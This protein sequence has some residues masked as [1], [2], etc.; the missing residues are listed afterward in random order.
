MRR[1]GISGVAQP[2][3]LLRRAL[4]AAAAVAIALAPVH[5]LVRGRG[6]AGSGA[7]GGELA[8]VVHG[9]LELSWPSGRAVFAPGAGTV[10]EPQWSAD[11]R[12]LAFMRPSPTSAQPG[13]QPQLWVVRAD[14]TDPARISPLGRQV[15][16]W[17][18]APS[19]GDVL[20]YEVLVPRAGRTAGSY[21]SVLDLA[22]PPASAR[23][24]FSVRRL[25]SSPGFGGTLAWAPDGAS[26]ALGY[27]PHSAGSQRVV[28]TPSSQW[29][30]RSVYTPTQAPG[31]CT[32]LQGWWPDGR[33]LLV[34]DDPYCSASIAADGLRL[35]SVALASGRSST[36]GTM[37]VHR[38]WV[39]WAPGGGLLG[40]VAGG[41]REA[42]APGK[43]I[44]LCPIPGGACRPVPVPPGHVALA[45]AWEPSGR[46][47]YDLAPAAAAPAAHPATGS[48]GTWQ[49]APFTEAR[50]LAW[51]GAMRL[52]ETGATGTP[53]RYLAAAGQGAH[54]PVATPGGLLFVRGTSLWYLR[55]GAAKPTSLAQG[56]G[57]P[58][59][60]GNYY[61]Y[62]AWSQ[63]FAWHS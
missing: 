21:R 7:L 50:A 2:A 23:G 47:V 11:G 41:D 58:S 35:T 44:E 25:E 54:D 55:Y 46:L 43:R 19:G 12:W 61:G 29:S 56:L 38:Q 1:A 27:R 26:L 22:A 10:S 40:F 52:Y 34:W 48:V 5:T 32:D 45:P 53:S 49:E 42:W 37:L 39:S 28:V 13:R 60:Y 6:G 59:P 18:W 33:G 9:R 16:A 57:D 4:G 24:P 63:D 62:I 14:G 15:T 20:A 17:A 30:P 36:L 31:S 8:V 3:A 51:Y